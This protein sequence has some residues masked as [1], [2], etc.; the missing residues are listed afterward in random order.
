MFQKGDPVAALVGGKR[1]SR[2]QDKGSHGNTDTRWTGRLTQPFGG[3]TG[4]GG[5]RGEWEIN[6]VLVSVIM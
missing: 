1:E 5:G 3:W 4:C 6:Q 2:F